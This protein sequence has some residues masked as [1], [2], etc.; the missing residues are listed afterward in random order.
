MQLSKLDLKE[1]KEYENLFK[2]NEYVIKFTQKT[3]YVT[4]KLNGIA[5]THSDAPKFQLVILDSAWKLFP[6]GGA[7]NYNP[8]SIGG[9]N[10]LEDIGKWDMFFWIAYYRI[11]KASLLH[12]L[13]KTGDATDPNYFANQ[14]A[15]VV[16]AWK[17]L[18]L[19]FLF[20]R[21]GDRT[22]DLV[23]DIDLVGGDIL[24]PYATSF[25]TLFTSWGRTS[26]FVAFGSKTG[27]QRFAPSF[28]ALT[29][30]A[31]EID[32]LRNTTSPKVYEFERKLEELNDNALKFHNDNSLGTRIE[33]LKAEIDTLKNH[34]P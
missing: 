22:L 6:I 21:K 10:K 1:L 24:T 16:N 2:D 15:K 8:V 13:A 19:S 27:G 20:G 11:R 33:S 32:G 30:I 5:N 18:G 23:H 34:T 12:N 17:I 28:L 4:I 31:R 26:Q 9:D 14:I 25:V 29:E 7:K 3:D